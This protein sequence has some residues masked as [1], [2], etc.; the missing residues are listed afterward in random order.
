LNVGRISAASLLATFLIAGLA[1]GPALQEMPIFQ[2]TSYTTS[3][4]TITST[5]SR[6]WNITLYL[7][8]YSPTLYTTTAILPFGQTVVMPFGTLYFPITATYVVTRA[9]ITTGTT[10]FTNALVTTFVYTYTKADTLSTVLFFFGITEAMV[11]AA[12]AAIAV[13]SVLLFKR[14]KRPRSSSPD[15]V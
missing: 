9:T 13:V 3:Y 14:V 7:V 11:V 12:L 1:Q 5:S 4:T 15:A 2:T 10:L 8:T 6:Y